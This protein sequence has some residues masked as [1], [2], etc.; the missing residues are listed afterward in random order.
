M[1]F[2]KHFDAVLNMLLPGDGIGKATTRLL[3]GEVSP[4]GRLTETWPI[5]YRDVPYGEK[6]VSSPLELYK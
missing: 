6:F 4:S 2:V 3:F 5:S 1:P